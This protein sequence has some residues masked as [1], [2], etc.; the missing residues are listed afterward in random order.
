MKFQILFSRKNK[1]NTISLL[2]AELVQR[3]IKTLN[4][5][6]CLPRLNFMSS[7]GVAVV[8]R[9]NEMTLTL[10]AP[11]TTAADDILKYLF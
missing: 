6:H 1:K 8:K 9:V 3:M 11:I 5:G 10:R 4:Y 7:L 2:S